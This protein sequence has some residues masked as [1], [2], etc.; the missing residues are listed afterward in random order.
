MRSVV[1]KLM[2][3]RTAV[4]PI[5]DDPSDLELQ[6][7]NLTGQGGPSIDPG[8][9]RLVLRR[10]PG[11]GLNCLWNREGAEL[12]AVYYIQRADAMCHDHESIKRLLLNHLRGLQQRALQ[13]VPHGGLV[14]GP[15]QGVWLAH[16]M[17]ARL[18]NQGNVNRKMASTERSPCSLCSADICH[19]SEFADGR[20]LCVIGMQ[21]SLNQ[22][23]DNLDPWV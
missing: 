5:P 23:L 19:S 9:L 14:S 16:R 12:F 3:R 18:N 15:A 13:Q 2:G 22:F 4:S 20:P 17:A 21:K 6:L 7:L 1:R 10:H 8:P 11:H